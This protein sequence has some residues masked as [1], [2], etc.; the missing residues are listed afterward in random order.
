MALWRDEAYLIL[1]FSLYFL[2]DEIVLIFPEII[3]IQ[4][5]YNPFSYSYPCSVA[6]DCKRK[7]ERE[8]E[9]DF[10]QQYRRCIRVELWRVTSISSVSLTPAGNSDY[11][12]AGGTDMS[13]LAV[14]YSEIIPVRE[15]FIWWSQG[16]AL[17]SGQ[18][19][20]CVSN[21]PIL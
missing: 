11:W 8:G 18:L 1:T 2:Q 7:R 16:T 13:C 20:V 15:H 17:L 10:L 3:A 5:Q 9:G 6:I 21:L 14:L 4:I 19:C 12:S